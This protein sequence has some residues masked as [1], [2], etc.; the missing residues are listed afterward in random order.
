MQDY[1]YTRDSG[2][3]VPVSKMTLDEIHTCLTNGV[4]IND[5]DLDT[6][7]ATEV[8]VR[9]RLQLELEIRRMT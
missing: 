1:I 4:E 7:H 6:L 9:Q 5:T 2:E 3:K 8:V